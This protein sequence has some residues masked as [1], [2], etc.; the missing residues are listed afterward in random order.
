MRLE[1]ASTPRSAP[2]HRRVVV[3]DDDALLRALL[4]DVL[5]LEGYQ[6]SEASDGEELLFHVVRAFAQGARGTAI[7]LIVSDVQ[8]PFCSGLDILQ[9]LRDAHRTTPVLLLSADGDPRL[10]ARIEALGGRFLEKPFTFEA[11][12]RA[13]RETLALRPAS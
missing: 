8:M 4:G 7:D 10:R 2:D 3:A 5:R 13:I 1:P 9:Q 11:L 12:L 6:V